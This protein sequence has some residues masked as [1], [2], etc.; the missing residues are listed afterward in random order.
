[1]PTLTILAACASLTLF[2]ASSMQS[3]NPNS[4]DPTPLVAPDSDDNYAHP[5]LISDSSAIVPGKAFTLAIHFKIEGDWHLY[6]PSEDNP[7]MEPKVKWT[8]P[9][10]IKAGKFQY[11]P[12]H[13]ID[14][15]A[16]TEHVYEHDLVL[17]VDFEVAETVPL[18]QIFSIEAKLNWLCCREDQCR[19]EKATVKIDLPTAA[20]STPN[21]TEDFTRWRDAVRANER[22]A[23]H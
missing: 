11:P 12:P 5:E 14:T 3:F 19:P 23:D 16:G 8:L 6:H 20:S 21:R 1:M 10:G 18:E 4:P 2:A 9:E 22:N 15:P 7:G 17:L 13:Q